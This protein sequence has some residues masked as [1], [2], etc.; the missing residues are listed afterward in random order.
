[1][2]AERPLSMYHSTTCAGVF[3]YVAAIGE[4]AGSASALFGSWAG[5][6]IHPAEWRPRLGHDA[7]LVVECT[8]GRLVVVG[9]NF[10]LVDRGDDADLR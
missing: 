1:M 3:P 6:D 2:M 4:M 9:V 8:E 5:V 7:A 10:D